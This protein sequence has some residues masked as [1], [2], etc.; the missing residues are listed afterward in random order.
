MG[1]VI[2]ALFS[3]LLIFFFSQETLVKETGGEADF[4]FRKAHFENFFMQ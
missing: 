2:K 3:F 1:C 4:F